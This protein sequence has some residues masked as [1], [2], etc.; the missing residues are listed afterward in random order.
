MRIKAVLSLSSKISILI[1]LI[2]V[3]ATVALN[4]EIHKETDHLA[5][6]DRL[7]PPSFNDRF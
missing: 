1:V 5:M 4:I 2:I 6:Q 7:D 3:I